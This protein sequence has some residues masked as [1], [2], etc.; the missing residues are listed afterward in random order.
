MGNAIFT[1][2][3]TS[4]SVLPIGKGGTGGTTVTQARTNLGVMTANALY[5]NASG[6]SGTIELSSSIANYEIIE[7]FY[8]LYTL[9]SDWHQS[10]KI[11]NKGAS[12]IVSSLVN[13]IGGSFNS[14]PRLKIYGGNFLIS[15]NTLTRGTNTMSNITGTNTTVAQS[16]STDTPKIYRIIGYTY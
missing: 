4:P 16:P 1:R 12:E 3:V 7:I 10:I 11:Y 15:A 13:A 8:M 9:S 6:N 14:N 5:Y 2:C